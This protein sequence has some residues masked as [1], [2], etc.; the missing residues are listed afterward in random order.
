MSGIPL[1]HPFGEPPKIR[2][3]FD[4]AQGERIFGGS[5]ALFRLN[6]FSPKEI[7]N[8]IAYFFTPLPNLLS[9]GKGTIALNVDGLL[10]IPINVAL[11][12]CYKTRLKKETGV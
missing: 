1:V 4:W 9:E 11:V 3:S 6:A 12:T 10:T 5:T 7:K 2:S 8:Q